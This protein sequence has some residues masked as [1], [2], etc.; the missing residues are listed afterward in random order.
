MVSRI[1]FGLLFLILSLN[2]A[3]CLP[4]QGVWTK[5]LNNKDNYFA[6]W[7]SMY[8]NSLVSV[9]IECQSTGELT[10]GIG[11]V[12]RM[13]QCGEEYI[14]GD[15][16]QR[17]TIYFRSPEIDQF[18]LGYKQVKYQRSTGTE[19][20]GISGMTKYKCT[21]GKAIMLKDESTVSFDERPTI[22]VKDAGNQVVTNASTDD[23]NF[24]KLTTSVPGTSPPP[25]AKVTE[26]SKTRRKRAAAVQAK[27][28][29]GKTTAKPATD[30]KK[31]TKAT[32]HLNPAEP[33]DPSHV[34]KTWEDGLYMFVLH[35]EQLEE[36]DFS[37]KVTVWM[38]ANYGYLSAME[39]PL[40]PFYGVMCGIY[41][42]FGVIWLFLSACNWRDL[43]R[44]QFWIGGVIILGMLEKAVFYAEYQTINSTGQSVR[45]AVVF[46]EIVSCGKRTLARMLVVI[47]SLGFGIVKPRL[48]PMLHR[49]IGMGALYFI[50]G[51]VE[52]CL[53]TLRP[54]SDPSNQAL[55]AS[56]PLAVL[57]S[58]ICW[59]V[60]TSLVQTTRTLRLRRNVVKLSLYRHFTNTLIFAIL[61]SVAF[62][63]WSI[64]EHKF[65]NCLTDWKEIWVD[66][67]Y[68]HMLFSIILMVIM[69]LWR[70][71][72]NNQRYA[73]SPLQDAADEE[74]EEPMLNDAFDGMKMRGMKG[75]AN[76]SP[77]P[78]EGKPKDAKA[79]VEDDLKWIEDNIPSSV[80]DSALPS[81]LDSDE[82]IM[83]TKFEMSKM[84]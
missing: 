34:A 44:I 70:P 76:G 74:D 67:A 9:N 72:N 13:T 6:I 69:I 21:N 2:C 77:K 39:W 36:K 20:R 29:T 37:A 62:M 66:D 33:H 55:L 10:L 24:S 1:L 12:F 83:T 73:F 38:K 32:P 26:N 27:P 57:D 30:P 4:E 59:W 68:W 63:I 65:A 8:N 84:E 45:G 46:A 14:G 48:G 78:R 60:F 35:I 22:N 50:L 80:A 11:W 31:T 47:V 54:K 64:K 79:K 42:I 18:G 23:K 81:L 7:K 19:V 56:I 82:E 16:L 49:V 52:A 17:A 71:T 43:L 61:A 53:R 40:L 58:A 3:V 5:V 28:K 75:Q 15:S 41:V 25:K 51:S